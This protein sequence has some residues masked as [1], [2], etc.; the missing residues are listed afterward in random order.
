MDTNVVVVA[1][2][3]FLY[4]SVAEKAGQSAVHRACCLILAPCHTHRR[5]HR[6]ALSRAMRLKMEV[7]H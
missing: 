6:M 1:R 5:F 3:H 4:K 7:L 2:L